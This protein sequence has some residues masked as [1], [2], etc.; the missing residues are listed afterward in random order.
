MDPAES[1]RLDNLPARDT[2]MNIVPTASE[3]FVLRCTYSRELVAKRRIEQEGIEC[4]VPVTYVRRRN[5]KGRFYRVEVPIVHNFIF[6]RSIKN[7]INRLKT[8]VLPYL[9][10]IMVKDGDHRRVMTVPKRQMDSF[11]A[12]AGNADV[13]KVFLHSE[14]VNLSE[15][16]R[17][18]I[19]AGDLKGVEGTFMRLKGKRG[20][21]VVVMIDGI[22][23]VATAELEP[24]M[25]EKI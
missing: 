5:A 16:D 24:I 18:R 20:K 17:V 8:E 23:G 11:I 15:G 10:Y 6:V 13:S 1:N 4:F 21:C 7:E 3:W 25:V 2:V 9:R 22:I 12:I 14:E 19:V